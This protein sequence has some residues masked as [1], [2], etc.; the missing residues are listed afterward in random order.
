MGNEISFPIDVW[1]ISP[2]GLISMRGQ[3]WRYCYRIKSSQM[4][5]IDATMGSYLCEGRSIALPEVLPPL[6]IRMRVQGDS[7][8]RPIV[9]HDHDALT[10]LT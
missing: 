3:G 9:V 1:D 8:A 6:G 7:P 10:C 4:N 5:E 2:V